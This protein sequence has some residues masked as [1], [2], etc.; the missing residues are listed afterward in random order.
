[1]LDLFSLAFKIK[2]IPVDLYFILANLA[3]LK[4]EMDLKMPRKHYQ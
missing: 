4:S 1:M 2:K 3:N